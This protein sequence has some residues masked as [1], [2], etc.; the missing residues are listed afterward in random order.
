MKNEKGRHMLSQILLLSAI[1]NILSAFAT[2]YCRLALA[3]TLPRIFGFMQDD[4]LLNDNMAVSLFQMVLTI[5]IFIFYGLQ[6][7]S[8]VR[9]IDKEEL[10][11]F[12]NERRKELQ[13]ELD[14]DEN[15]VL[16]GADAI[17]IPGENKKTLSVKGILQL[18]QMWAVILIGI[19]AVYDVSVAIY[20]AFVAEIT[21][22]ISAENIYG[23]EIGLVELYNGTHGFKYIGM[24]T[25]II[26]GVFVTGIFLKD[27]LLKIASAFLTILFMIA[28]ALLQMQTFTV[29]GTD[30]GIV[31]TAVI[32]HTMQTVGLLL[33]AFYLKA[34]YKEI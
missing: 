12:N 5:I 10:S 6:Y 30:Y 1:V 31:W 34:R 11:A 16:A 8:Y 23:V 29:F 7:R 26:L 32:F 2:I 17:V 19:R 14:S 21:D 22:V 27:N 9:N 28:F 4:Q 20:G 24:F 18:M 13:R 33:M 3:G 15:G 25:A